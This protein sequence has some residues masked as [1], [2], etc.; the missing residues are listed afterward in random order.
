MAGLE[1]RRILCDNDRKTQRCGWINRAH[2]KKRMV[3][4]AILFDLDGT[5][6]QTHF[7]SCRAAHETLRALGL[8]DVSDETVMQHIGD[9]A[10]AFLRA[11]APEYA[12]LPAFEALF[13][14]NEHAALKKSGRLYDGVPELIRGLRERG[15]LLA[16]CSYG[17]RAY[18]ETALNATGIRDAFQHL[19]CAGE[20]A[21]KAAAVRKIVCECGSGFAVVIGDRAHDALA[22][23]E[24]RLPFIAV[25][26][27]Y[28]A[29]E[30]AD[31][32]FRARN[33]CEI[34]PLLERIERIFL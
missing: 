4:K 27:G 31:A 20:H 9:P 28:G 2:G 29:Q 10:D 15:Y 8:P 32:R 21:N 25:G 26:Y 13:D 12:D 34:I 23:K 7:H 11:L 24:N 22:A 16:I 18:V 14:V 30:T 3:K 33:P 19:A 17:S 1:G 6:L 5:L